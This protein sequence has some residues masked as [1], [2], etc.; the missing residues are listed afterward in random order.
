MKLIIA[1]ARDNESGAQTVLYQTVGRGSDALCCADAV[2]LSLFLS[3]RPT[4]PVD[5]H[6]IECVARSHSAAYA[7][8]IARGFFGGRMVSNTQ[9]ISF[10]RAES[11]GLVEHGH[12]DTAPVGT[13]GH[14]VFVAQAAERRVATKVADNAVVLHFAKHNDVGRECA[15]HGNNGAGQFP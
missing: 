15:T 9:C 7:Q 5:G 3:A 6:N 13:V 11:H 1:I 14:N 2:R 12:V 4:G 10:K 8:H